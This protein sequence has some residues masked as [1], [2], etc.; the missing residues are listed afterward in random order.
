LTSDLPTQIDLSRYRLDPCAYLEEQ[1]GW[2]PWA[3]DADHPGQVEVLQAYTAALAAQLESPTTPTTNRIRVEAGHNVGKT[4]L[5]A[6]IVSHFFDCFDPSV[7]YCFAPGYDQINDL[8]FKYLRSDRAGRDLPG[9]VLATPEIKD[10]GRHFVKGRATNDSHGQGSE[11]I[12]GQHEEHLLFVLD[13]AEALPDF[14]Y[15]AVDSMASGGVSIVLMLA[16]PRTRTSQFHKQAS[17]SDTISFRISCLH[18]PNVIQEADLIPGAVRRLWVEQMLDNGQEQHAEVVQE[19]DPDAYTFELAW[20]PGV[21]YKPDPLFLWRVRGIAPASTVDNT[22][23]PVG[24]YQA[25]T[26]RQPSGVRPGVARIG[27]DVAR[28]GSDLG[29]VYCYHA[30]GLRRVAQIAQQDTHAYYR[31][32]REEGL[33][34]AAR[35]VTSLHIRVDAGGGYG[36]GVVDWLTRDAE[37]AWAI[38]DLEIHE[39]AFGGNPFDKSAYADMATELYAHAGEAL[40]A[41][42]VVQA[43]NALEADLT[44]RTYRWVRVGEVDVKQLTNKELFKKAHGRSPDDGDGAALALAPDHILAPI[45]R[46]WDQEALARLHGRRKL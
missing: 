36:G 2:T 16:N 27:V 19:H 42:A 10:T 41:I 11:R 15:E 46:S 28:Y 4:R 3:G 22:M 33:R 12:Q 23:I 29:T 20:R 44:E 8:L 9:R 35:G 32:I 1:L 18:H 38:T 30:G 13:E 6:G 37:L 26:R 40:R 24:R 43:P 31:A 34:L 7:V 25:A 45:G 21:I 14:V 39:V 17:R 5:A